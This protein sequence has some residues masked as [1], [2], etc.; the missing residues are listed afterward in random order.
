MEIE[1]TSLVPKRLGAETYIN[2]L[3]LVHCLSFLSDWN[4]M[5]NVLV[6][7]CNYMME[8]DKWQNVNHRHLVS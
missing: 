2:P 4:T 6:R 3:E 5:P 1:L 7:M 8:A